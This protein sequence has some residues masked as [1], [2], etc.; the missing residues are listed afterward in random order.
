MNPGISPA[1]TLERIQNETAAGRLAGSTVLVTGGT[2]SFGQT[3]V[4]RLLRTGCAEVR[5]LSR[6][7]A[8]QYAMR[9]DIDDPRLG[10]LLGD[11]RDRD[12]VELAV[13]GAD[14]VFHA[15]ALKQVP[16]CEAFPEQAVLTNVTGSLNVLRA[17]L[18]FGVRRVVC[19][20]TDKAVYPVNAMGM[21]KALMEKLMQAEARRAQAS[22]ARTALCGVRYGNVLCSRGSVVPTFLAQLAEGRKPG[23]TVPGM[24]RFLLRL[25][26]AVDLVEIALAEGQAGDIFVRKSPA[27][28]IGVLAAALLDLFEA[29]T[30]F[31]ILGARPGEKMHET[32]A[33]AEEMRV[34]VDLGS[35]WR[36]PAEGRDLISP[37]PTRCAPYAR[38]DYTSAN[39]RRLDQPAVR[40]LLGD[41]PEVRRALELHPRGRAALP[42][43]RLP[44]IPV[45]A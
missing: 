3:V 36:I 40:R 39:T 27:C 2:G 12:S 20:S 23:V 1:M 24:T 44:G 25:E 43:R 17:A 9:G 14:F 4:R 19:L 32:L 28:T 26:E 11:V 34:A 8:K 15:A 35:A 16:N 6:D 22:G 37:D 41:L 29:E 38:A 33:T 45:P 5:V 31:E 18:R 13:R 10:L 7:E 42:A 21:T 30:G